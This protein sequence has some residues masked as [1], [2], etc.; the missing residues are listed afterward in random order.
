[1]RAVHQNEAAAMRLWLRVKEHSTFRRYALA[2]VSCGVAL[3]LAWPLDAPSSCF[4]LAVMV[5]GLYGGRGPA[6]LSVVLS[7]LAFDSSF[8]RHGSGCT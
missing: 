7:A 8:C 5:S 4:F 2:T 3:A 1:M 6:I